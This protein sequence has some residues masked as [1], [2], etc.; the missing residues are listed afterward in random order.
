[1][2]GGPSK[3]KAAST[4]YSAM[5][6]SSSNSSPGKAV[7][8]SIKSGIVVF[9][10]V[11]AGCAVPGGGPHYHNQ[12]APAGQ[13]QVDL[14]QCEYESIRATANY[15]GSVTQRMVEESSV[16]DYCMRARGYTRTR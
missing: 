5:T 12:N 3:T 8:S 16:L 15:P 6:T 10:L 14:R 7:S 2:T 11:V 9:A 13:A 1:M 4:T